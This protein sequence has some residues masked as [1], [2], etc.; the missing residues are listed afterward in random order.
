GDRRRR[1][2]RADEARLVQDHLLHRPRRAGSQ[3]WH[4]THG[5]AR[6]LLGG[7]GDRATSPLMNRGAELFT[8]LDRTL[9]TPLRAQLERAVCD[10]IAAGGLRPGDRLPAS[11]LLAEAAGV[12][13]GVVSEAYAQ[14]AA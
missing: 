10:A 4:F 14:L 7:P 3:R 11:R 12:S 5:R 1:E 13:R 2:N 8:D 9:P 6:Y